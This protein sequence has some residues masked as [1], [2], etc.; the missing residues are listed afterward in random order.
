VSKTKKMGLSLEGLSPS[1]RAVRY[2]EFANE[3]LSKARETADP[4][5]RAEYFSMASSWHA[6]AAEIERAA[7]LPPAAMPP[8]ERPAKDTGD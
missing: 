8:G 2:R 7:G 5:S 3:A 1:Q 4:D 6:M